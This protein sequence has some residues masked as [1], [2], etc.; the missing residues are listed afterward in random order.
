[1]E[2]ACYVCLSF[3]TVTDGDVLSVLLCRRARGALELLLRHL[4]R[5]VQFE[6]HN[7]MSAGGATIQNDSQ[8][9][10]QND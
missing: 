2:R 1:M 6:R 5:V 7:S 10:S 3:L 4:N 9:D 8:N